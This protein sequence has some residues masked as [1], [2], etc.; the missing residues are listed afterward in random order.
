MESETSTEP[1]LVS[2]KAKAALRQKLLEAAV[3][4]CR[5]NFLSFVKMFAP[6]LIPDFKMGRHIEVVCRQLQEVS[7][8]RCKRLMLFLPPRSTKSWIASK[9][10]PAWYMGLNPRDELLTVSHSVTLAEG[11]GR[12]VRD[13]ISMDLYQM[14]FP[15]V[16]IRPDVRAAGRWATT[17][18]GVYVAAGI[19]SQIAGLGAH[20]A[21]LD[22]VMS[23]EDAFSE[24]GKRYAREW[25]PSGLR[26]RLMPGGAI[27][28]INTRYAE[29]DI[30]GW[31]L[32]LRGSEEWKVIK[33][34]AWLDS[35]SAKLL[36][37]QEGSSYFPEWKPDALLKLD[38]AEITA[39]HGSRYWQ[40]LYMQD[41]TPAEGNIIKKEW[42]REWRYEEP[43]RCSF[44]IQSLDTAFSTKKSADFSVIETW[45]VFMREEVDSK[46]TAHIVGHAI[47]LGMVRGRMEYPELRKAAQEAYKK[48]R[49]DVVIIEKKA[50][51]QSLIQDLRRAGVPVREYTPDK[52]KETRVNAITPLLESGRVW[53]PKG[54]AWAEDLKAE[55]CGFPNAAHDDQVDAMAAALL[56]LKENWSIQAVTDPRYSPGKPKVSKTYWGSLIGH[57]KAV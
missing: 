52:D 54:R 27:I 9:L 57:R 5:S 29:D 2:T 48:H 41:P 51:G 20:I 4:A 46:G 25:Y 49:P 55:A 28:I 53:L 17:R 33:I 13:I 45:G 8:G 47:L 50:S 18:G 21:V 22:D 6:I 19:K 12:T 40:A 3:I 38:Q 44:I 37:L 26:T 14:V 32:S 34:P 43:P 15:G 23:E 24:A 11:F 7:E 31:L 35:Q 42:F 36:N 1:G 39:A 10:F 56:Y 30:S 16:E